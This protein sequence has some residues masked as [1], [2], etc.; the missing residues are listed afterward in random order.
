MPNYQLPT[1][2]RTVWLSLHQGRKFR[3]ISTRLISVPCDGHVLMDGDFNGNDLYEYSQ[4]GEENGG[5]ERRPD[6]EAA[7][8]ACSTTATATTQYYSFEESVNEKR[9]RYSGGIVLFRF[10]LLLALL[11]CCGFYRCVRFDT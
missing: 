1:R 9:L 4:D 10:H 7:G 8:R 5:E 11:D 3:S 2:L 6:M